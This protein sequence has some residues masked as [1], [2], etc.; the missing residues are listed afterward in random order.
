MCVCTYV[1]ACV[2]ACV[3]AYVLNQLTESRQAF[4]SVILAQKYACDVAV[5][6]L[7]RSQTLGNSPTV[8]RNAVVEI[9]SEEWMRKQLRHLDGN[10]IGEYTYD[11]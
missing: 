8:L 10:V 2:L 6:S 1:N 11:L 7:L 9:H 3:A 4:F 5:V